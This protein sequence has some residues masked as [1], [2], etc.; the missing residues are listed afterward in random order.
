[1]IATAYSAPTTS[2]Q[3]W[4]GY[5]LTGLITL[6]LTMDIAMKFITPAPPA[7]TETMIKLGYP[8]ALTPVLGAILLVCTIAYLIPRTAILG[9]ILLTGYLGGA[10]ATHVRV[11]ES[12][13]S[14]FFSV[15]FGVLVWGSL[16]FRD[17]RVRALIPF[18]AN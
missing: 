7:V 4:A 14:I 13:F 15:A 10:T 1:M 2:K 18:R 3:P 17:S 16:Y 12:P 9:A 8:P 11:G 6:F 5:V